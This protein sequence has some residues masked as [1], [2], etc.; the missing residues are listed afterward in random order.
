MDGECE[1]V[2]PVLCQCC[3]NYNHDPEN[4]SLQMYHGLQMASQLGHLDCLKVLLAAGA[5]VNYSRDVTG[6]VEPLFYAIVCKNDKCVDVLIKAG[7]DVNFNAIST[8]AEMGTETCVKL[9][10]DASGNPG[11]MLENAAGKDR[12]NIVDLLIKAGADVISA[13]GAMALL[14]AVEKQSEEC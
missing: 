5:N 9:V 14:R 1:Q 12:E 2:I 3:A 7:A 8:A 6:L 4:P 11:L 13:N 10:L